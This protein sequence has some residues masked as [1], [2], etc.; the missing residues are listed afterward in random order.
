[1]LLP[2]LCCVCLGAT[3]P[4]AVHVPQE[5]PQQESH[6][7]LFLV[8]LGQVPLWIAQLHWHTCTGH[9]REYEL[10][11]AL[12]YQGSPLGKF[13]GI[14][15]GRSLGGGCDHIN[16]FGNHIKDVDIEG[17]G[18]GLLMLKGLGDEN[19]NITTCGCTVNFHLEKIFPRALMGEI[20]IPWIFCPMLVITRNYGSLYHVGE[21]LFC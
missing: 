8:Q 4:S 5:E 14:V 16:H 7:V 13:E 19:W 3:I 2:G 10:H 21:N 1:M 17:I 6:G 9:T 18:G 15:G 12:I 20:F 11:V